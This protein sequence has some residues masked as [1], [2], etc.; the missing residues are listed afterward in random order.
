MGPEPGQRRRYA[1]RRPYACSTLTNTSTNTERT[2]TRPLAR[3]DITP[4]QAIAFLAPQ[5]AAGL[6]VLTQ[7][8]WYRYVR[9]REPSPMPNAR[10]HPSLPPHY[11]ASVLLGASSLSLVTI[12]PLMKRI[13]YWPQAVLG[14]SA[15]LPYLLYFLLVTN[16][17]WAA[18]RFCIQL[19]CA[20][21]LVCGGRSCPLACG[22]AAIC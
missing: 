1:T 22:R 16:T 15:T 12:Y 10:T 13:T 17:F 19:G 18:N 11:L 21:R 7:L 4:G 20:P 9:R 2:K 14:M 3:G 5:L 8:N 6:A